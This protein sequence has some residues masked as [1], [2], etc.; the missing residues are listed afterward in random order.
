MTEDIS[1]TA[2]ARALHPGTPAP[3]FSL[4]ATPDQKVSLSDF[5]ITEAKATVAGSVT[6]QGT[7]PK[8][9]TIKI[10][11]LDRVGKVI[12]S[13]E[14]ALGEVAPGKAA[15]F[16]LTQTPGKEVAAFRYTRIE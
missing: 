2:T 8:A 5:S 7:A 16:S 14:Q 12:G 13:K 10:D 15:R 9:G 3:G 4:R 11:F 1:R 6:N